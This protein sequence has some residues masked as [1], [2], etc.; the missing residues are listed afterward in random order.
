MAALGFFFV[1]VPGLAIISFT[2]FA[3]CRAQQHK[4]FKVLAY[5]LLSVGLVCV[6]TPVG[7]IAWASL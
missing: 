3:A 7:L 4:I 6:L 1:I 5:L 2:G